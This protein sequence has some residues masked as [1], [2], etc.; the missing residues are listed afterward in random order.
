[1]EAMEN[2]APAN[3]PLLIILDIPEGGKYS[4]I[5]CETPTP[6]KVDSALADYKAGKLT[7]QQLC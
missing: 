2:P 1:M 5:E 7:M 3:K 6:E 4:V